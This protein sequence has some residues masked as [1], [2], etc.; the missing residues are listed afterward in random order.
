MKYLRKSKKHDEIYIKDENWK[1]LTEEAII[2]E[3]WKS[4]FKQVLM[5]TEEN[6][7]QNKE[8]KHK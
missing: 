8:N 6:N 1:I 5:G 4:Y 3:R 7:E 2:M